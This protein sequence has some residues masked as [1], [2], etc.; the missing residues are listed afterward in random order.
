YVLDQR[1]IEWRS[2]MH[3]VLLVLDADAVAP[4]GIASGKGFWNGDY[5]LCMSLKVDNKVFNYTEYNDD[6]IPIRDVSLHANFKAQYYRVIILALDGFTITFGVCAPDSCKASDVHQMLNDGETSFG[7][8]SVENPTSGRGLIKDDPGAIVALCIISIFV[9]IVLGAT[10]M[11]IFYITPKRKQHEKEAEIY[12]E[13]TSKVNHAYDEHG[14]QATS[15]TSKNQPNGVYYT[16]K[17]SNEAN[18]TYTTLNQEKVLDEVNHVYTTLHLNDARKEYASTNGVTNGSVKNVT[19]GAKKEDA[20]TNGISNGNVKI[21][22]ANVPLPSHKPKPY[23]PGVGIQIILAFSVYS[24]LPQLMSVDAP[25]G[26][27]LALNCIRFLSM[28]Y[29]I[30]GHTFQLGIYLGDMGVSLENYHFWMYP[31]YY[32]KYHNRAL[33]NM[34]LAVDSFFLLSGFLVAISF[35]KTLDRQGGRLQ[36]KQMGLYFFHRFWRLTPVYMI[37]IMFLATLF[38]YTGDGPLWPLR[39]NEVE[40]CRM[41]WWTNLLYI[42]NLYIP[43]PLCMGWAWYLANDMQ[44]YIAAPVFVF[45]LYKKPVVGYILTGLSFLGSIIAISV[46]HAQGKGDFVQDYIKPYTRIGPYIIG[47]WL[48]YFIWRTKA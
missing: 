6:R 28:A 26:S 12:K 13:T 27:Y 38:K 45:A 17:V 3:I 23:S 9:A 7:V 16:E 46:L 39:M 1:A 35:L 20:A 24:N 10:A 5:D 32:G 48:G 19:P 37:L 34:Q 40:G 41:H 44:F 2:S 14:T 47:I 29:I 15:F 18:H 21:V 43:G 30:L 25:K 31:E 33:T 4:A 36:L 8:I 11:D 22:T 42:N